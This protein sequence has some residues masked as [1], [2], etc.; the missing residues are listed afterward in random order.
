[1]SSVAVCPARRIPGGRASPW[2]RS[3]PPIAAAGRGPAQARNGDRRQAS[4]GS[5]RGSRTA[6]RTPA[7]DPS[8]AVSS[9]CEACG[10]V[11]KA[12]PIAPPQPWSVWGQA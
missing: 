2:W 8:R 1:L 7:S 5:T 9:N 11:W 10:T 12:R 3:R 4:K 6:L